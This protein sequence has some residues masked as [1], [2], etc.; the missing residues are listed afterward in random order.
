MF[1]SIVVKFW[2]AI[3]LLVILILVAM[4]W[5]MS[6][7]FEALYFQQQWNEMSSHGRELAKILSKNHDRGLIQ[8]EIN[9]WGQISRF[10]IAVV[11]TKGVVVNSSDMEHA[12]PGSV[13][14]PPELAQA[15]AGE[16][17]IFKRYHQRFEQDM[18]SVLLPIRQEGKVTGAVMLH[19][20][21]VHIYDFFDRI[22]KTIF[23]VI[24][25]AVFLSTA[26]GLI[27]ARVLT[28]PLLKMNMVAKEM[29]EGNFHHKVEVKSNDEVGRLGNTLNLLSTRLNATLQD[30]EGKNEE[31]S[32]VLNLQKDFIANVSH[33]LRSPL[34]LIR[35]YTEAVLDGLAARGEIR[36]KSLHI[37]MDETL[38]LSRL[39]E[40]L[41]TLTRLEKDGFADILKEIPLDSVL[42]KVYQKFQHLAEQQEVSLVLEARRQ[43]PLVV[44]DEDRLAQVLTNLVDNALRYSPSGSQVKIKAE[45][46]DKG[47]QI[48]VTDQGPG[49]PPEDLPYIWERFY[50][51]DKA[52]IRKGSGI[53]LGL[54][55]AQSIIKAHGGRIWVESKEGEGT[56]FK[57]I[58][59]VVVQ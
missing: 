42:E 27:L 35:G 20:P 55:I 49:I 36:E 32:R 12:P 23:I 57:F 50:K 34:F 6:R 59:P 45:T 3:I 1:R 26:L 14:D 43:L 19:S 54:P 30:L 58:I 51:V 31:L 10:K 33:E 15:L 7:Q 48:S 28:V 4:G 39:V 41:L 17:V 52:R 47:V 13:M 16:E 5:V 40:D 8:R 18:L 25:T 21:L 9:F 56:S 44:G 46:I 37:V 29:A 38:R 22:Q 53:G 24:I 2:L 11:D